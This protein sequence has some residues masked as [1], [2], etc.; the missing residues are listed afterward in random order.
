MIHR[1][2]QSA[3]DLLE[4]TEITNRACLTPLPRKNGQSRLRFL[5]WDV[6]HW[7]ASVQLLVVIFH[8]APAPR[9]DQALA[10]PSLRSTEE[11]S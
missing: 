1:N 2:S 8:P 5:Y 3:A 10:R 7:A 6:D 4:R 11:D 9:S